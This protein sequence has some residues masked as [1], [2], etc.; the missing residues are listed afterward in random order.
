M[1]RRKDETKSERR[2][3]L[4]VTTL[5]ALMMY[6]KSF[7]RKV[8]KGDNNKKKYK[9]HSPYIARKLGGEWSDGKR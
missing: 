7:L 1:G 8:Q 5:S 3:A 2:K 4:F 6:G 9:V